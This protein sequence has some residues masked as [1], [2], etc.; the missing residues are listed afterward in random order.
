MTETP[1]LIA[2]G[3]P[4]GLLVAIEMHERGLPCLLVEKELAPTSFPKMDITNVRSMEHFRRLG[5]AEDVRKI[6]VPSDH[7][8]DVIYCTRHNEWELARFPYASPDDLRARAKACNDGTQ[9]LEPYMRLAQSKLEH[10]LREKIDASN[11][12]EARWGQVLVTLEQDADGVTSTVRNVESGENEPIRSQYVNGLHAALP[13]R[14]P[15]RVRLR[16]GRTAARRAA[17]R[18]AAP[19]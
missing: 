19:L 2:G 13:G 11:V 1:V 17:H 3:G 15:R 18:R 5:I 7:N 12:V 10:L 4:I 9:P 8:F 14:R 6:A 16:E